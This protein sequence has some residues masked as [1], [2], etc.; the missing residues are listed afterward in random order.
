MNKTISIVRIAILLALF[1]F[2][3]LFLLGEENK[4]C[5]FFQIIIDKALALAALWYA[6]RLYKRWAKSDKWIRAY[7]KKCDE[8]MDAP[9]PCYIED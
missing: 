1:G 7:D 3:V 6:G 4:D 8:V 9:N 5:S 2:G